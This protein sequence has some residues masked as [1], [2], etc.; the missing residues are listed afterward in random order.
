MRLMGRQEQVALDRLAVEELGLTMDLLMEHAA[1]A[2]RREVVDMKPQTVSILCGL[3]NNAGDGYA[4][5]RLLLNHVTNV[6]VFEETDAATR[7]SGVALTNRE[8]L[9]KLGLDIQA[10]ESYEAVPGEVVVDALFGTAFRL[11]RGMPVSYESVLNKVSEAKTSANVRVLAV[12]LPS[13]VEADSGLVHPSCLRADRTI[14]FIY[15][16]T[17][18]YNYPGRLY[19]GEIRVD[20]IGLPNTWLDDA[21][22]NLNPQTPILLD[23]SQFPDMEA[24][25]VDG[26]KGSH[27]RICMMAGSPGMGGAAVLATRAAI[28]GGA[29]LLRLVIPRD[30]YAAV[31]NAVPTALIECLPEDTDRQTAFFEEQLQGQAAVLVGPGMGTADPTRPDLFEFVITAVRSA[32]RLILDA[33]AL[34][35]LSLP[36]N[37]KRA[38]EALVSRVADGLEPAILTPHP[39]EAGRLLG[40]DA[41]LALTDRLRAAHRLA[42]YWSS[43]VVLKG[44]GTV[45]VSPINSQTYINTSGNPGLGKGGSGDLLAGL[46]LAY[47]GQGMDVM[48]A[49]TA[50]VYFHGLAA[51]L[52][53]LVHGQRGLNPEMLLEFLPAAYKQASE[54]YGGM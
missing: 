1:L 45:V 42:E 7:L 30:L 34:N 26:H 31:L 24:L 3:G 41:E 15:A 22:Q 21:W 52:A 13:G 47:L 36:E 53:A 29:G 10:F 8:R 25:Q 19:A 51:D 39:G 38:K 32:K 44:A 54:G 27:G 17:G 48:L 11:E 40:E 46:I 14:S 6:R 50:G 18:L 20:P 12:D 16:K 33:D 5:A 49:V 28:S 23:S 37:R 35:L 43:I 4:A 9:Q 2:V